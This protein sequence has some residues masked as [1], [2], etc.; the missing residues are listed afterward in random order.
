M[1][2]GKVVVHLCL[3]VCASRLPLQMAGDSWHSSKIICADE[4]KQKSSK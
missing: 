2:V 3:M 4:K 1:V